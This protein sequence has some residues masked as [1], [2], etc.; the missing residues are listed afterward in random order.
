MKTQM[1]IKLLVILLMPV[2]FIS[3]SLIE[4]ETPSPGFGKVAVHITDAP[5]PA[6]LVEHV[7]VTINKVELRLKDG[8]CKTPEGEV[9]P[10]CTDGYLLLLENPVEIDLMQLRN[11]LSQLLAEAEIPVGAYNMIRLYIEESEIVLDNETSFPLKIPGGS[12]S[13]LKILLKEPLMVTEEGIAE[14]LLD[15]DLS[16]SFIAQ[17]NPKS[18]KG[19]I[20]FIFKPV[21]RAVN[22]HKSG[23]LAGKVTDATGKP[24]EEALVSL[25]HENEVVTTALT[26]AGGVFKIIG[27]PAGKYSLTV[28]KDGY[29]KVEITSVE[30]KNK[31]ELIRNIVL[32]KE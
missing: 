31:H 16:R 5:F 14:I 26:N 3:C 13:G 11:G 20:G 10:D 2:L 21:I 17:G 7:F 6:S 24:V 25:Y 28:E 27:I 30:V 18:K 15:F 4:S 19:I 1:N 9:I 29:K 22:L 32:Q 8:N 23:A 12:V